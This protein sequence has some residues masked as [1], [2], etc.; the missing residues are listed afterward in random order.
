M[1]ALRKEGAVWTLLPL[2]RHK[3]THVP[4]CNRYMNWAQSLTLLGLCPDRILKS[5]Y[6]DLFEFLHMLCLLALH[7]FVMLIAV[8]HYV[9][10][11]SF[12]TAPLDIH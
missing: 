8:S 4:I 9:P 1:N 2:C 5:V 6:N 3:Q 10:Y 12:L 11:I 7:N